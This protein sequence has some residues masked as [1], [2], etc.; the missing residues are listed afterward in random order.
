VKI[1]MARRDLANLDRDM[2]Q[3][4][5][6]IINEYYRDGSTGQVISEGGL[7]PGGSAQDIFEVSATQ[8][9][10]LGT[11]LEKDGAV[12]R[13]AKT[14]T[15]TALVAGNLLES[16]AYGGGSSTTEQDLT[17]ATA[18]EDE[19]T[20]AYGTLK[21]SGATAANAFAEGF[22]IAHGAASAGGGQIMKI[23]SHAAST[24]KTSV[25][26]NLEEALPVGVSTGATATI[27]ANPFKAV[28]KTAATTAVGTVV[29]IPR[30]AVPVATPYFWAQRKGFCA[31]LNS[32][33]TATTIGKKL[34]RDLVTAGCCVIDNN[35]TGVPTA[36]LTET[37]GYAAIPAAVST[38][39]GIYLELE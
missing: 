17:V 2:N 39:A 16:A 1:K 36:I 8:N 23:A 26:F 6:R 15:G 21:S 38:Y 27:L 13:Y 9:Y 14:D 18:S 4:L 32:S 29:G 19:D 35:S 31:C 11:K 3:S 30:V 33:G 7:I 12:Y 22:Y 20:F 25:K 37:I 5:G 28:K 10:L 24:G 34:H